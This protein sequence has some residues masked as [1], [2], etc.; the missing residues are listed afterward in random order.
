MDWSPAWISLA[1]SVTAT[2]ITLVVGLAAAAW[3]ERHSGPTLALLDGIFLLPLVL[4]PTVVGFF[5]LLLFGRHGPLGQLLLHFG[6]T[7]CFLLACHCNRRDGCFVPADVYNRARGAGTGRTWP[8]GGGENVGRHGM[9]SIS[10]NCPAVGVA[11]CSCRHH[12][13]FCAGAGR[14]RR[15]TDD[16]RKY[17]R[18]NRNNSDR[19]LFCSGS[20]RHTASVVLVRGGCGY[21]AG[22]S[23]RALF[24][25]AH[26]RIWTSAAG[27]LAEMALDVQ[28]EK[29]LPDFELNV[30]FTASAGAPLSILGPSG[31]GK[32]ML[33]RC[34]AGLERPDRG[35]IS[36]G[37]EFCSTRGKIFESPRG[38]G[39][40]G[41][42][43]RIT[44]FS[45]IERW[46]KTLRSDCVSF[47]GRKERRAFR[48]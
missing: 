24:L 45:L 1:T 17:S 12:T 31:A 4:P 28:L 16:C 21:F 9:A 7:S 14:I 36:L 32:T 11:G 43:F 2:A 27:R 38:E 30:A 37:I 44:R 22:A 42:C 5:L 13:F 34:I 25:D 15:N 20:G 10:R 29:K 3:R 39:E 23:E 40:S 18:P 48:R 46:L 6:A 19:Y 33:L 47:P 35:R 8:I 41:W 26:A